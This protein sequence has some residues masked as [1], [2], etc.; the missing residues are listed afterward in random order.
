MRLAVD[1]SAGIITRVTTSSRE[2]PFP[3]GEEALEIVRVLLLVQ[4]AILVATTIE[5]LVWNLAFAAGGVAMVMSAAA[6]TALFV[7]RARLRTAGRGTRRLIY[8]VEGL[9]LAG[10]LVDTV[11]ALVVTRALPPAVALLTRLVIPVAVIVL[12]RRSGPRPATRPALED[13]AASWM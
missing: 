9:L 10:L 6:A 2:A 5:A 12:L 13:A 7:A 8:L 4:G 11:L 3:P 1:R